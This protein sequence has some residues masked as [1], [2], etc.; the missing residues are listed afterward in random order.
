MSQASGN[1]RWPRVR[2]SLRWMLVVIFVVSIPLAIE[3]RRLR[4][5]LTITRSEA[6]LNGAGAS[7]SYSYFVEGNPSN[8]NV[9]GVGSRLRDH[10]WI[11]KSYDLMT[12]AMLT[13]V[14]DDV[15]RAL[16][17]LLEYKLGFVGCDSSVPL[18]DVKRLHRE[19]PTLR[20]RHG[21]Q[22]ADLD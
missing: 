9:Q 4:F 21:N 19:L 2:L 13:R 7:I 16:R 11:D 17:P 1:P 15:I 5:A 6:V 10:Y 14:D 12:V 8:S 18:E 20:L 22:L 3:S